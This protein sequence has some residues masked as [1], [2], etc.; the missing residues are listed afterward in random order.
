LT[1][2]LVWGSL[3]D[4]LYI[5]KVNDFRHNLTLNHCLVKTK[6]I[7]DY[8]TVNSVKINQDPLFVNTTDLNFRVQAGSPAIDGGIVP[9]SVVPVT[10]DLDG[11]PR[12]MG[13][14]Y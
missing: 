8:V 1:N 9:N 12:P 14:A 3:D 2:C 13:A 5:D 4:E 6:T 7:P 10:D 11:K